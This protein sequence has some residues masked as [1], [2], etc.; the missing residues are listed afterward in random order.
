MEKNQKKYPTFGDITAVLAIIVS[1]ISLAI[2]INMNSQTIKLT[3]RLNS[4]EYQISESLKYDLMQMIAILKTINAKTYIEGDVDFSYEL[5]AIKSIQSKPGY[6]YFLNRFDNVYNKKTIEYGVLQLTDLLTAGASKVSIKTMSLLILDELSNNID[7]QRG[8]EKDFE[9]VLKYMC[10]KDG[11]L[12]T[13]QK[14]NDLEYEAFDDLHDFF[15]YLVNK[16]IEDQD[17]LLCLGIWH[18]DQEQI[19]SAREKGA[20]DCDT[21]DILKKYQ[22]EYYIF[23]KENTK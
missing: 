18:Q 4:E 13:T 17:V 22:Q 3:K 14:H 10:L 5:E 8:V 11:G 12:T 21:Y 20:S 9:S 19:Q 23:S 15:H 6:H 7:L 1:I 16:G 2:S